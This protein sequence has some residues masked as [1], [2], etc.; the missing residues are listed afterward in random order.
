[1]ANKVSE[2]KAELRTYIKPEKKELLQHYFKTGKGEYGEEDRFLGVMV[3]DQRSVA[4]RKYHKIM[5]R[6]MYRYATEK[7]VTEK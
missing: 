5:P 6:V 1:M 7:G 3:P 2:I 4:K